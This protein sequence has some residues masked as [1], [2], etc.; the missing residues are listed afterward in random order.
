MKAM[1]D[2]EFRRRI[3]EHI[4]STSWRSESMEIFEGFGKPTV[5]VM[6]LVSVHLLL[7]YLVHA[8]MDANIIRWL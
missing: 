5:Y 7:R 6:S 8:I 1:E 3:G 4:G 2:L